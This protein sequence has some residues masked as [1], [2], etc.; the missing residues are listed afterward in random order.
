MYAHDYCAFVNYRQPCQFRRDNLFFS[1]QNVAD[2]GGCYSRTNISPT[3]GTSETT[4][5]QNGSKTGTF[6]ASITGLS[7]NISY[8]IRSYG[9]YSDQ[10]V[11]YGNQLMFTTLPVFCSFPPLPTFCVFSGIFNT[12]LTYGSVADQEGNTYKTI[13][14]VNQTWMAE[15]LRTGKYRNGESIPCIVNTDTWCRQTTGATSIYGNSES[16][17]CSYGRLYNRYAVNDSRGLC[18][19]GWHV[20]TDAEFSTLENFLGTQNAGQKMKSAGGD[21][22][23]QTGMG[24]NSS[25]FS[26]V[27]AGGRGQFCTFGEAWAMA[28]WWTRDQSTVT[29]G[30]FCMMSYQA[31]SLG[32]Y[33]FPKY[34]GYSVR[35][36]KD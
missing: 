24:R 2:E 17:F 22:L 23:D 9:V 16:K 25:G 10:S 20:P 36:V 5:P 35:C 30:K 28:Y 6:I 7:S 4:A 13:A 34:Y 27:P 3:L 33:Q 1:G 32:H 15:N 26:A 11:V 18:P 14:I 31:S 8:Y 19:T 29:A 12:A 21:W